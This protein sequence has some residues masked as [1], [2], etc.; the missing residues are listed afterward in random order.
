MVCEKRDEI[1]SLIEKYKDILF[2][3]EG[4]K[5]LAALL[6][7]G[8]RRIRMLDCALY[9]VVEEVA[10]SEKEVVVLTDMDKKG[11][12]LYG[13]LVSG[14]SRRGVV[15]RDELREALFRARVSHVEGLARFLKED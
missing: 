8:V 10:A 3:V 13:K 2:I 5:D 12:E 7:L 11:K 4:K 1:F 6:G 9:K 14:L 15:V